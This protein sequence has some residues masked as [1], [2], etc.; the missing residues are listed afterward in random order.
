MNASENKPRDMVL[1]ALDGSLAAATAL[2]IALAVAAQ[3]GADCEAL[4]IVSDIGGF[5]GIGQTRSSRR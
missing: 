4:H 5:P 2:P 3:L 1:V